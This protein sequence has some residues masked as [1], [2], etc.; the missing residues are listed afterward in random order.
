MFTPLK[1]S[2][3]RILTRPRWSNSILQ[4]QLSKTYS[5]IHLKQL[6]RI[7]FSLLNTAKNF[8]TF[9]KNFFNAKT[10]TCKFDYWSGLE[11]NGIFHFSINELLLINYSSHMAIDFFPIFSCRVQIFCLKR[12]TLT[13]FSQK[14]F[15]FKKKWKTLL[16][17]NFMI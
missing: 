12:P 8:D 1:D 11:S 9:T 15:A 4:W 2:I 16:D 17:Y 14:F 6:L 7:I 10:R 5:K 13:V 3:F